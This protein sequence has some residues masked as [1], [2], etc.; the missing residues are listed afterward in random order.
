[1]KFKLRLRRAPTTILSFGRGLRFVLQQTNQVLRD[2]GVNILVTRLPLL[3]DAPPPPPSPVP[4]TVFVL[5]AAPPLG[6]SPQTL[7]SGG[8]VL[9]PK[10]ILRSLDTFSQL[11]RISHGEITIAWY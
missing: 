5:I 6:S 1:M 7:L 3:S 10:S 2:C 11:H 8:L 9:C 4:V